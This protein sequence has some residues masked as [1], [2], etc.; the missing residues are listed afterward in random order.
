MTYNHGTQP[1]QIVLLNKGAR[2]LVI[3]EYIR[4]HGGNRH[5]NRGEIF[6]AIVHQIQHCKDGMD[7]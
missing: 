6:H 2:D 3:E 7:D 1:W 5:K 4:V